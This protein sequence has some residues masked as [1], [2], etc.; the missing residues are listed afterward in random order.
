MTTERKTSRV[1]YVIGVAVLGT[2]FLL[3][4]A[5]SDSGPSGEGEAAKAE[6]IAP[7]VEAVV[8]EVSSG[9]YTVKA[10]GR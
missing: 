3:R 8:A 2:G 10:P 5:L 9:A 1:A 7:L 4:A 6:P